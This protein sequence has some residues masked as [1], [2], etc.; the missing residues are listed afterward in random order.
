M[1]LE[2]RNLAAS[3]FS[4]AV[5]Y[6]EGYDIIAQSNK[7][8]QLLNVKLQLLCQALELVLKGWLA[9]TGMRNMKKTYGHNLE[10]CLN[11]VISFHG[12][13]FPQQNLSLVAIKHLNKTYKIR[14]YIFP[15]ETRE[16]SGIG[17]ELQFSRF[18]KDAINGSILGTFVP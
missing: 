11:A 1:S 2:V 3:F 15:D 4:R 6:Y 7:S 16:M 10:T 17:N 14:A 13:N 18:V 9:L 8:F 5:D 12:S